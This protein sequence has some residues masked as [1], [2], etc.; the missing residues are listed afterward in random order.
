MPLWA[1]TLRVWLPI[2]VAFT[3]LTG[4]TYAAVQQVYRTSANDPQVQIARDTA[5]RLDQG[6]QVADVVPSDRINI[7]A[8]LAPFVIVYDAHDVALGGSGVLDG[9]EPVPPSGVLALARSAGENR[10]TWQPRPKVRI[11]SVSVSAKD[12]RVVLAGRSLRESEARTDSLAQLA[13]LAW[14][15]GLLGTLVVAAL[16]EG[17]AAR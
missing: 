3:A 1:R 6:D 14:I 17:A 15:L 16:V 13:G 4:L 12:G 2:A 9:T 11:A 10:V 5:A 7:A 8:S